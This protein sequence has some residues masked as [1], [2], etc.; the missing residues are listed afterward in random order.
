MPAEAI[1]LS[2]LD[3]TFTGAGVALRGAAGADALAVVETDLP[4]GALVRLVPLP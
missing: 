1:H 3:D 2:A 4:A